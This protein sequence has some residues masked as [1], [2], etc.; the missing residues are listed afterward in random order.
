MLKK[1][2]QLEDTFVSVLFTSFWLTIYV[3]Y[4]Y[5]EYHKCFVCDFVIIVCRNVLFSDDIKHSF[6]IFWQLI[7]VLNF[8]T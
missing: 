3:K 5:Y 7:H 8:E 2:T 4:L 6:M 1:L